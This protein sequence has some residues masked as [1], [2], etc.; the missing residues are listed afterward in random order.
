[1]TI[2][3]SAFPQAPRPV[4]LLNPSGWS[5]RRTAAA[6][7]DK[8]RQGEY[9]G[10]RLEQDHGLPRSWPLRLRKLAA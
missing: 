7:H 8:A 4:G 2:E 1:M 10:G 3:R 6:M 5:K 9:T